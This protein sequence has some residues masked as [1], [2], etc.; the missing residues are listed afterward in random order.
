MISL[1]KR[2]KFLPCLVH[3]HQ[4]NPNSFSVYVFP[5]RSVSV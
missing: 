5:N 3:G 2:K 1:E 4:R